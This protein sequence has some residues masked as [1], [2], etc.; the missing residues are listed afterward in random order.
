MTP[1]A[2]P[3]PEQMAQIVQAWAAS[4]P[5]VTKAWLYGSRIKGTATS[6]SDWDVAISLGLRDHV[7]NRSHWFDV[8]DTWNTD[9]CALARWNVHLDL[10]NPL[11]T[12]IVSGGILEGLLVYQRG[13]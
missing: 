1:T 12:P 13:G 2:V 8:S 9:L 11:E 3:G 5:E 6:E 7:A 4:K 10:H